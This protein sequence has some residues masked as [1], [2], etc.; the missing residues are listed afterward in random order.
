MSLLARAAMSDAVAVS[1]F[2]AQPSIAS[3]KLLKIDE[4][5]LISG[6]LRYSPWPREWF[7]ALVAATAGEV[8][9]GCRLSA[10]NRAAIAEQG[11]KKGYFK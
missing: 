11:F 3:I 7:W 4:I 10:A 8:Q 5:R 2:A 9:T 1:T 6:S